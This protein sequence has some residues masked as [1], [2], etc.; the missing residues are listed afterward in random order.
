MIGRP[1]AGTLLFKLAKMDFIGIE[2]LSTALPTNG[3]IR[4]KLGR[5]TELVAVEA[6]RDAWATTSGL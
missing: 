5:V 6:A 3:I 2:Q 1:K 4:A